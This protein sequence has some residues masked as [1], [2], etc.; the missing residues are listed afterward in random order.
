MTH[1]ITRSDQERMAQELR[2]KIASGNYIKQS[3]FTYDP[4]YGLIQTARPDTESLR[5]LEERLAD[6]TRWILK[7]KY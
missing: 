2:E 6:G 3:E 4:F 7:T 5:L 1:E